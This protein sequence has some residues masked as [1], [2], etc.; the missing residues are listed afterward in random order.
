MQFVFPS[1]LTKYSQNWCC[2]YLKNNGFYKNFDEI[3]LK[4]KIFVM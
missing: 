3:Y 4:I 2:N 1:F